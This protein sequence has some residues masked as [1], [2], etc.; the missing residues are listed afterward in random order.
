[1][2]VF[3]IFTSLML[4][5]MISSAHA[6]ENAIHV[7]RS[8]AGQLKFTVNFPLPLELLPSVFPGK[9]GYATGDLGIHA[10]DE[11]NATNDFFILTSTCDLR[12][13]LVAK[14]PGME[15]WN[16]TGTAHMAVGENF[17]IGPPFFDTHPLWNIV[18]GTTGN[19]YS[20]TLK[21]QDVNGVYADSAPFE[22][23]FMPLDFHPVLQLARSGPH[24]A[25][26]RWPV[27][28]NGWIL[29]SAN[30]PTGSAWN[31]VTNNPS[32]NGTNFFLNLPATHTQQFFRLR[33]P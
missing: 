27:E 1:M 26:L 25:T 10:A 13:V 14:T 16:D 28:A 9:P 32:L 20:V 2:K 15:V 7:G 23:S 6:E 4:A 3:P 30:S 29:E 19:V 33:L 12:F 8:A 31:V 11:E 18:S 22:F 24:S 5:V 17:F 21:L